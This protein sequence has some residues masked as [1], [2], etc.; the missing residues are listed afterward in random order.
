MKFFLFNIVLIG[1]VTPVVAD[2]TLYGKLHTSVDVTNTGGNN[3][4]SQTH[5]SSNSSR[6]GI[7]GKEI[8]SDN[9]N[10]VYGVEWGLNAVENGR[11]LSDRNQYV[12]L[13]GKS[14]GSVK[15]GHMDTPNKAVGRKVEM[16]GD[17]LGDAR[18][19]TANFDGDTASD[20]RASDVVMYTTPEING[21][22]A[23]AALINQDNG[24]QGYSANAMYDNNG[25]FVGVGHTNLD[26][27]KAPN[28]SGTTVSSKQTSRIAASYDTGKF[29]VAGMYQKDTDIDGIADTD[30]DVYGV[31]ASV[32]T[33]SGK[34]KVQHYV[35]NDVGNRADAGANLTAVGY[36]H[37]LSKRTKVYAQYVELDND[38]SGTYS[39]ANNGHGDTVTVDLTGTESS[40][41]SGV[42]M[43]IVHKF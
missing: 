22:S 24:D 43:G 26:S 40:D 41:P 36:D 1:F 3:A 28:V 15:V 4:G 27:G 5:I 42:S 29:K 2:T 6:I 12:G 14:W 34:I 30:R 17:E 35:T 9:I 8:I 32:K 23:Q 19:L 10:A 11:G 13:E 37:N 31:G 33:A 39:I 25:L 38:K 21:F 16:F 18:T 7:K 20:R